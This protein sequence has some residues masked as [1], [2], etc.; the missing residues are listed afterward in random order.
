VSS[1][2]FHAGIAGDRL[3]AGAAYHDGL[4]NVV[5][6]LLE[7]VDLQTRIYLWFIFFLHFRN[8]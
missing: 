4:G 2:S 8:S 5:P 7:D 3:L 6:E 1:L